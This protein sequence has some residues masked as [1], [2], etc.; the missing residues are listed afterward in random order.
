M[1]RCLFIWSLLSVSLLRANSAMDETARDSA[2]ESSPDVERFLESKMEDQEVIELAD[3][4][5]SFEGEPLDL[6]E[7]SVRELETLPGVSPFLAREIVLERRRTKGFRSLRDLLAV[8]GMYH[9]VLRSIA[10]FVSV[11]GENLRQTALKNAARKISVRSRIRTSHDLQMKRGYLDGTF[12]GSPTRIYQRFVL[13]SPNRLETGLLLEKDAGERNVSDFLSA[14]VQLRDLFGILSIVSGDY[15]IEAGQGVVLWGTS[16]ISGVGDPIR[17]A[18]RSPRGIV[19]YRSVDENR[20]FRGIAGTLE[21]G[22]FELIAFFSSNRHDA[23]VSD[24][25]VLSFPT[26][27]YHRTST[28]LSQKRAVRENIVGGSV[29][30]RFAEQSHLGLTAY[31]ASFNTPMSTD[32]RRQVPDRQASLAA[33]DFASTGEIVSFFSEWA[34]G[35]NGA[36]GGVSAVILE[37]EPR[38]ALSFLVRSYPKRVLS[39]HGGVFGDRIGGWRNGWGSYIGVRVRPANSVTLLGYFDLFRLRRMASGSSFPSSGQGSFL[40]GDVSLRKHVRLSMRYE[41]ELHEESHVGVDE[42]GRESRA[43]VE[44]S[45]QNLRLTFTY[46]VGTRLTI[47]SRAECV[48]VARRRMSP[49]ESGVLLFT[50]IQWKPARQTAFEMR[51]IFFDTDSYGSRLYEF[52]NDVRGAFANAALSGRGRRWYVLVR[53]RIATFLELSAKYAQ[54]Y[55]DDVKTIGSG[56]DEILGNLQSRVNVQLDVNL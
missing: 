30:F 29:L 31:T 49:R 4:V 50:E 9:D 33:F 41:S 56:A 51:V 34:R 39:R 3:L 7:A 25:V 10:P 46:D 38:V 26:A 5:G 13:S 43:L 24:G 20:F 12:R 42:Q 28:E 6:N 52:E 53:H 22:N 18:K 16:S 40:Q 23:H 32:G 15:Q 8:R 45:R 21:L 54:T 47:R 1:I 55:R 2:F 44:Q 36:F 17:Y 11:R 35:Q 48:Q 19:P 27:G 14:Y 37:F